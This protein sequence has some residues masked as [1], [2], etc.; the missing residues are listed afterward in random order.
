LYIAALLLKEKYE[1]VRFHM[2]DKEG[3]EKWTYWNL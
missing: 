3:E 1:F 2:A